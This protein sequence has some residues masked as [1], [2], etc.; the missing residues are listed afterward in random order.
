MR[1]LRLGAIRT[2]PRPVACNLHFQGEAQKRPNQNNDRQYTNGFQ[3]QLYRDDINN[4]GSDEKLDTQENP[5]A[6][7]SSCASKDF[8]GGVA[9]HELNCPMHQ[10]NDRQ[11]EDQADANRF[12]GRSA[13]L[14]KWLD[15]VRH[16]YSLLRRCP[17]DGSLLAGSSVAVLRTLVPARCAG[18]RFDLVLGSGVLLFL[19]AVD[20]YTSA[21]QVPTIF[22]LLQPGD[23]LFSNTAGQ[24]PCFPGG[25]ATRGQA[26]GHR[27]FVTIGEQHIRFIAAAGPFVIFFQQLKKFF[28]NGLYVGPIIHM[29]VDGF[30]EVL[31]CL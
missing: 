21:G 8:T 31:V 28:A 7:V 12:D 20:Y 2:L 29:Q 6:K 4:V 1:S 5:P 14:G 23:E 19:L 25:I 16:I 24:T 30:S 11:G 22:V 17:F 10:G 3:C 15:V 13:P 9:A 18:I 27:F 26:D